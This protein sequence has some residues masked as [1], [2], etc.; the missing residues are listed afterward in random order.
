VGVKALWISVSCLALAIAGA[1]LWHGVLS[2]SSMGQVDPVSATIGGAGLV[3]SILSFAYSIRS[4]HNS[5]PDIAA[6]SRRLAHAVR[7][8]ESAARWQLLGGDGTIDVGFVLHPARHGA[9]G[10][11]RNGKL[12]EV[13]TYFRDLE[14]Q[15]LI[16]TGAPGSGKT[17]AAIELALGLLAEPDPEAVPVRM[18][19][20][21]LDPDR[22]V[23]DWLVARLREQY[24]L[25]TKE[26]RALV[27]S[28]AVLPVIDGLDE[29][30]EK[31]KPDYA[32]AQ[33][34][35]LRACNVYLQG[36]TKSALIITC[37]QEQ[38]AALAEACE[39]LAESAHVELK[40]VGLTAAKE[41]IDRRV[42]DE[43]RWQPIIKVLRRGANQE[44]ADALST[45]WRLA[46]ATTIYE[47]RDP[48][49][50]DYLREP[51]ELAAPELDSEAKIR[52]HLLDRYIPAAVAGGEYDEQRTRLWL[53]TLARY[54]N[55]APLSSTDVMLDELWP[56]GGRTRTRLVALAPLVILC[57][58]GAA[59][60]YDGQRWTP[61]IIAIA[62]T[63]CVFGPRRWPQTIRLD[64]SRVR[65]IAH[66]RKVR[67][68]LVAW[69]AISILFALGFRLLDNAMFDTPLAVVWGLFLVWVTIMV[70]LISVRVPTMSRAR[71]ADRVQFGFVLVATI[72]VM[73]P[74]IFAGIE[75]GSQFTLDNL[76]S[77]V[78]LNVNLAFGA[79]LLIS[80]A[81]AP[82]SAMYL[83]LLVCTRRWTEHPLPWRLNRF[84]SW[85]SDVGLMRTA[86]SCYQFR[87]KE[88]QDYLAGSP[89]QGV[90]IAKSGSGASSIPT[91]V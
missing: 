12:T 60:D 18:S 25:S 81:F 65:H 17:V 72:S 49:T 75:K 51:S 29:M 59:L 21:S 88:L 52:E 26:A 76:G 54:L 47:Q 61:A 2:R 66:S 22:P 27:Q 86:G 46:M 83:A 7:D 58:L 15:R 50:G 89:P 38:Y 57:G 19:A 56:L 84:L 16:V 82:R 87:H 9:A 53:T 6:L 13:V 71:P 39:N 77:L 23:T 90:T 78:A 42:R 20:T 24:R 43:K 33:A 8:V 55:G 74:G 68:N 69:I 4:E 37:R 63:L 79:A 10:A 62:A 14:P 32:S 41:F 1:F 67:R 70:S 40:S 91:I 3:I 31:T 48:R 30:S 34:R 85:S 44:L 11:A 64:F 73:I 80:L 36:A 35:V 5:E 28:R 45:P